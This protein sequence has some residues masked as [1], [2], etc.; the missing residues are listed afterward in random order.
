[1]AGDWPR[2]AAAMELVFLPPLEAV[3]WDWWCVREA[4]YTARTS[5]KVGHFPTLLRRFTESRTPFGRSHSGSWEPTVFIEADRTTRK[6]KDGCSHNEMC[7]LCISTTSV[8]L[9]AGLKRSYT[10]DCIAALI[11]SPIYA[12]HF[13]LSARAIQCKVLLFVYDASRTHH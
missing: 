4:S 12:F 7:F 8:V 9:I 3:P 2:S 5:C 10:L 6:N 13:G 1:M 11:R